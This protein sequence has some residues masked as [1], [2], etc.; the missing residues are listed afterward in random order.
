MLFQD[1]ITG[2]QKRQK[3]GL[4]FCS[5]YNK[6]QYV[7]LP[8]PRTATGSSTPLFPSP[9]YL[10]SSKQYTLHTDDC[11]PALFKTR[12]RNSSSTEVSMNC[13]FCTDSV[14]GR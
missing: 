2:T 11:Q 3:N 7:R 8:P 5:I 1:L 9:S 13:D 4:H 6:R 12:T 14:K 10:S